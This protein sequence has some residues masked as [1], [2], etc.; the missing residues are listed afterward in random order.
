[1]ES[2]LVKL[3]KGNTKSHSE[4]ATI[5]KRDF[6]TSHKNPWGVRGDLLKDRKRFLLK[7]PLKRFTS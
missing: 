4:G 3:A 7:S 6:F 5:F 1:V 2:G